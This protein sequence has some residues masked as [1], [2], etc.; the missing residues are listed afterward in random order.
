MSKGLPPRRHLLIIVT[1]VLGVVVSALLFSYAR[2]G[3][4][5]VR[6]IDFQDA[7]HDRAAAIERRVEAEL[8][9]IRS[10]AALIAAQPQIDEATFTDFVDTAR[11]GFVLDRVG[12]APRR[13]TGD[14]DAFP[15]TLEAPASDAL[16]RDIAADSRTRAALMRARDLGAPTSRDHGEVGPIDHDLQLFQPVFRRAAP[17]ATVAERRAA[18]LGVVVGTVRIAKLLEVPFATVPRLRRPGGIDVYVYAGGVGSDTPIYVHPSRLRQGRPPP[19]LSRAA[20]QRGVHVRYAFEAGGETWT[21]IARP[22]D[23]TLGLATAW[24]PWAALAGGLALTVAVVIQLRSHQRRTDAVEGEVTARTAEL[25][26]SEQRVRAIIDTAHDGI[27]TIDAQGIVQSFNPAAEDIF[28]YRAEEV[29]GRDV[30]MLVPEPDKS[31]HDAYLRRYLETGEARIIGVGR[32]VSG[33]RRDGSLVP[34]ELAISEMRIDGRAP[35]FTAMV[36]DITERKRVDRLKS[37]F[38]S[39]VSHELRT[40]LTSIKGSLGLI[41][42]GSM[43]EVPEKM[44]PMFDIAHKN[45]DRL[46]L[47]INDIL[48]IEKIEAGKMDFRL[49]PLEVMALVDE[50]V[51][52]HQG[53]GATHGVGL[54]LTAGLPGAMIQGDADRLMQVM[55]NLLSNAVKFSPPG[56]EVQLAVRRVPGKIRISV[57]DQGP[58]IADSFRPHLFEKF[59]QADG[60][61]TRAEGGTGL[62][63]AIAKAIVEH[64]HGHIEV[65]TALGR[66]TTFHVDFPEHSPV[67]LPVAAGHRVLI[68]EDDADTATLL[69]L[70]LRQDGLETVIAHS[71]AAAEAALAEQGPFDAMTVDLDLPDRPGIALIEAVRCN[72]ATR[73]LPIVVVSARVPPQ[74]PSPDVGGVIDWLLKPIEPDQLRMMVRGAIVGRG[75]GKPRILHVEDDAGVAE[76]I[77]ALVDGAA[78]ITPAPTLAAARAALARERYD[79]VILDLLLPDGRGEELL[80]QLAPAQGPATPVIVFSAAETPSAIAPYIE[81]V[82]VKSRTSNEVLIEAIRTAINGRQ[83]RHAAPKGG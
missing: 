67:P 56:G 52:A 16:G 38:V 49:R 77:A 24:Q 33:Q 64:H 31:R 47:L 1:T 6:A 50:A 39:T 27:I 73:D 9:L 32:E 83:S 3:A 41:K 14:A 34:L 65:Q 42:T 19:V 28:G 7:A 79:L 12:W 18:L 69:A 62:G 36:R 2:N 72:P 78:V 63:L 53:Y 8:G 17:T 23:P 75:A 30:S 59:S 82:L 76:V 43:G 20:A 70:I 22:I 48:D 37:E 11:R 66:G 74:G 13:R 29:V 51:A 35:L 10:V 80:P 21:L 61:D 40:P 15:L 25:R 46:V 60:S 81:A 44:R 54:T 58:G 55:A 26:A 68:C 4:L 71:A 5:A 57:S 45:C